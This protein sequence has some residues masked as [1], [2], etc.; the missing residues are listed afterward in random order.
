MRVGNA[1]AWDNRVRGASRQGKTESR[2]IE[3]DSRGRKNYPNLRLE[4]RANQFLLGSSSGV[5]SRRVGLGKREPTGFSEQFLA[6]NNFR[7]PIHEC[8]T[9]GSISERQTILR[10]LG[11]PSYSAG[12]RRFRFYLD[13]LLQQ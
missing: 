2:E 7:M 8:R 11:L 3:P 12:G 6:G 10:F 13:A 9:P 4:V 5:Q 1:C